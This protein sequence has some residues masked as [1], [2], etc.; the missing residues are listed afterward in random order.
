VHNVTQC[1][2]RQK[3]SLVTPLHNAKEIVSLGHHI[4][5][6]VVDLVAA[7]QYFIAPVLTAV[8]L[9]VV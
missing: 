6:C 9:V 8:A 1:T 4:Q 5:A 7:V 2:E 3:S